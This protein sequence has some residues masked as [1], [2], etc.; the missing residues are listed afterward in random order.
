MLKDVNNDSNCVSRASNADVEEISLFNRMKTTSIEFAISKAS[1]RAKKLA[2]KNTD[3][4]WFVV[5]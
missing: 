3:K 1:V 2:V 4:L 5:G